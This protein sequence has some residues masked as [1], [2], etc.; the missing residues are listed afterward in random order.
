MLFDN[1][2]D[3]YLDKKYMPIV[4]ELLDMKR[5]SDETLYISRCKELNTWIYDSLEKLERQITACLVS[6]SFLG[7]ST[8]SYSWIYSTSKTRNHY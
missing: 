8:T 5:S 6:Q 4:Q 7:M 1:L 2:V 3:E